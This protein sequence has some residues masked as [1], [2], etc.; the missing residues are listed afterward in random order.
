[1]QKVP[2]RFDQGLAQGMSE[3]LD[4]CQVLMA[5]GLYLRRLECKQLASR[6]WVL[7]Y[8][9]LSQLQFG[10]LSPLPTWLEA[11]GEWALG[12]DCVASNDALDVQR[13]LPLVGGAA[14]LSTSFSSER[15]THLM[16]VGSADE[17]ERNRK[18][19]LRGFDTSAPESL[20]RAAWG[21]TLAPLEG[22]RPCGILP[23]ALANLLVLDPNH[24]TLFPGEDLPRAL[25][26]GSTA[27][28]ISWTVLAGKRIGQKDGLQRAIL[29]SP[30]YRDALSEARKRRDEL[31]A[32]ARI[33]P[34]RSTS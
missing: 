34:A 32:R 16:G 6:G 21:G 20:L 9:P 12:T 14:A 3:L 15:V 30:E 23:G 31:F 11:Q 19:S 10:F 1:M 29:D 4:G 25:A 2:G 22:G 5:H 26:Y 18:R 13:E 8:C 17:V 24:P 7:A 28:A 27:L 33:A